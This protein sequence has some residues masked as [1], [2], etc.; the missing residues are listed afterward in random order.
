MKISRVSSLFILQITL[1]LSICRESDAQEVFLIDSRKINVSSLNKQVEQILRAV[2]IPGASLAIIDNN[3]IVFSKA[4]GT[5]RVGGKKK[6]NENT[7]FEGASLS[8]SF[9]VY[10][11]MKLAEERLLDLDKPLW[12]Y[13]ENA[14]IQ[15]DSRS[16]LITARMV[17]SHSS[18][19]ENWQSENDPDKL[20]ILSP[21]GEK[22]IYSGEGYNYLAEIVSVVTGDPYEKY[23]AKYVIESFGL[24]RT[25][26]TYKSLPWSPFK[27]SWP[28]NYAIGHNWHGKPYDKWKNAEPVPSSA[29]S[30][31]AAD[32]AALF[33]GIFNGRNLSK[34][35]TMDL[36]R[37]IVRIGDSRVFYGPGFELLFNETDSIVSHGGINPGFKSI[38]LYSLVTR[39]GLVLMTNSDRG[40]LVIS[41]LCR[42]TIG[43]D[44]DAFFEN[45]FFEQYPGTAIGLIG[46]YLE[47]GPGPFF[48]AVDQARLEERLGPHTCDHLGYDIGDLDLNDALR[49]LAI[50]I[51]NNRQNPLPHVLSGMISM[52]L[53]K[54]T[55]AWQFFKTAQ[56]LNFSMWDITDDVNKCSSRLAES[57]G[58]K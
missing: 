15:H 31:T 30:F 13:K 29:N 9:L 52:E 25:Y 56:E 12:E 27:L 45:S 14:A 36:L 35:T 38:V 34:S 19:L 23:V 17:L 55:E 3:K 18:G 26:L 21:P 5:R 39:K 1:I 46:T 6:V 4:Y 16:R 7:V 44:V 11:V 32:Y 49:V 22:F 24:N 33:L 43:L 40:D 41:E 37:P 54:Y 28:Q 42:M 2:G 20:E 48:D 53:G 57:R 51:A 10:V 58:R 47:K 50:G 8:K